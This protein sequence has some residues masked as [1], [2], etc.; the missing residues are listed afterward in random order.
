[1]G[2]IREERGTGAASYILEHTINYLKW[3]GIKKI[4]LEVIKNDVRAYRFYEK[5]G[6]R[7]KRLLYSMVLKNPKNFNIEYNYIPI[8]SRTAYIQ[9]LEIY[10]AGRRP[11]WQREPIS[12]LLSDKRYNFT[13]IITNSGE[14]Y[15]VWGKLENNNVPIIDAGTKNNYSDILKASINFLKSQTNCNSI[16]ISSVP[17]DD[18]LFEP[19]KNTGF[20]TILIQSEMEKEII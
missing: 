9:A 2:V 16:S 13:K 11:N 6:F 12:L 20:Q 8:E 14:G 7:E 1:M 19:L 3:R 5:H 15:L 18:F 10:F 4:Q 17:E